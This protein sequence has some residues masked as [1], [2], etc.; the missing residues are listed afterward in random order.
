MS[1]ARTVDRKR[2]AERN[3]AIEYAIADRVAMAN[4]AKAAQRSSYTINHGNVPSVE[5]DNNGIPF[6]DVKR[7]MNEFKKEKYS[8][9]I[10]RDYLQK[11]LNKDRQESLR[12]LKEA[13]KEVEERNLKLAVLEEHFM[14]LNEHSKDDDM[15][16]MEKGGLSFDS[17]DSAINEGD[18]HH[19]DDVGNQHDDASHEH[20]DGAIHQH[21][22]SVIY[23]STSIIRLDKS[24][25]T[26]L[27]NVS[28]SG[29]IVMHFNFQEGKSSQS[30]GL[31]INEAREIPEENHKPGLV[32]HTLG[33]PLQSSW[34]KNTLV[35]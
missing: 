23:K 8:L 31:R 14:A 18:L 19:D 30:C 21:D 9:M 4:V 12:K 16:T 35:W 3:R 1:A 6:T 34:N 11:Q 33:Y 20:D 7:R 24:Y 5:S 2:T 27:K 26:H 10:E 17:I 29:S 13:R 25:L 15:D 28:C 22:N 32:M